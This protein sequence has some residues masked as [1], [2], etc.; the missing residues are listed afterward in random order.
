MKFPKIRISNIELK[1]LTTSDVYAYEIVK[2]YPN[3]Y[4]GHEQEYE[5]DEEQKMYHNSE[6]SNSWIAPSLFHSPEL[7]LVVAFFN[8]LDKLTT[9]GH[10]IDMG[11]DEWKSLHTVISIAM[12]YIDEESQF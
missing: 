4:Y 1:Q 9:T 2:W 6:F 8:E 10:L 11:M 12:S 7:C 5:Y 3:I